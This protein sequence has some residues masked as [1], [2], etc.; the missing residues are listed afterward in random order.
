VKVEEVEIAVVGGGPA[1]LLSAISAAKRG[2]NVTLFDSKKEIGFYEHCAGLLSVDGLR[3]LGLG[4]LPPAIVQNKKIVGSFLISPSGKI[5]KLS[6][7][8]V[9]AVV[10]NRSLFNKHLETL[11]TKENVKIYNSTRIVQIKRWNN[12]LLLKKGKNS[13]F[14]E[15]K[16]KIAILA[17]GRFPKLNQQIGLPSPK[18]SNVI[19]TTMY[20]MDNV[21]DIDSEFVELYQTP[22]YA[23]GFFAWIIPINDSVAKV[24]LGSQYTPTQKLLTKFIKTQPVAK[25]KLQNARILKR[26]SGAIPLTSFIKRTYTDNVMVVGDAAGQTKPTTGG[27]VILGG[28][29]AQ[30]AGHIASMAVHE[31][32]LNKRFLSRYEKLWKK[33]MKNN[34]I[35]MKLVRSYL[36]SLRKKE[37]ERLFQIMS[38][39][40]II[41]KVSK[42]GDI[43]NQKTIALKMLL[44][45]T[46][47]PFIIKTGLKWII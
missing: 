1:G 35:V 9:T 25:E 33:E 12:Y 42:L 37:I 13:E 15:V 11:A 29:A 17:E 5:I 47:I 6:K 34:L 3:S 2:S 43:D 41:N 27:G 4:N 38:N 46:I 40:R 24:G 18:K 19:F 28:K 23:P 21:K 36:N 26:M 39:E 16:A 10:V 22:D 32:N 20:L 45:P 8:G 7:K 31:N 14:G 44:E 30:I